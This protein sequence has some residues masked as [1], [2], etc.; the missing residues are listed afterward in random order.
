MTGRRQAATTPKG[1]KKPKLIVC[2]HCL[3]GG[4][5]NC[6]SDGIEDCVWYFCVGARMF[7][8]DI[9]NINDFKSFTTIWTDDWWWI[10][11][12]KKLNATK[13]GQQIGHI[14]NIS[15]AFNISSF[16]N[17]LNESRIWRAKSGVWRY[18]LTISVEIPYWRLTQED[19]GEERRAKTA[20]NWQNRTLHTYNDIEMNENH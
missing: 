9:I 16:R 2:L 1:E 15:G 11:R 12:M 14:S 17:R 10:N 6:N 5:W 4:Y 7:S 13:W 20:K 8:V 3:V 18:P 19:G